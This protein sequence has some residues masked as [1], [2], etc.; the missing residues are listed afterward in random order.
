MSHDPDKKIPLRGEDSNQDSSP[1]RM[2]WKSL[3]TGLLR[4]APLITLGLALI[5]LLLLQSV[6]NESPDAA[7]HSARQGIVRTPVISQGTEIYQ[8]GSMEHYVQIADSALLEVLRVAGA[9]TSDIEFEDVQFL[10][11]NGDP[12]T[13]QVLHLPEAVSATQLKTSLEAVLPNDTF[14]VS[15]ESHGAVVIRIAG[16]ET[17]RFVG[18]PPPYQPTVRGPKVVIVIDDMGENMRIARALAALPAPVTFAVWPASSHAAEVRAL[19][20]QHD[21]DILVHLPMEPIGYPGDNPGKNALFTSM[22][23]ES[24]DKTIRWNLDQVPEAV[25]VNNHMGSRFTSDL[26]GMRCLMEQLKSRRLFFLDS[27]TTS[28][29]AGYRAAQEKNLPFY[30]RDVFLDNSLAIQ[31]ILLQLKKTERLAQRQGVAIAIGH[32]HDQTVRALQD[33]LQHRDP[34]VSV[35]RLTSLSP[36]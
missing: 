5:F 24:L 10:C 3:A 23:R 7:V 20:R 12:Y 26:S 6:W 19:A 2:R 36:Q 15:L 11:C 34:G 4:P 27:R 30:G 13:R 33:W 14:S 1:R 21:L 32:P 9:P 35:V 16:V 8:P 31:D 22:T 18:A 29:S 17:H 25:G 28:R